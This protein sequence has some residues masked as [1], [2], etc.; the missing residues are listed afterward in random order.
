LGRGKVF[1]RGLGVLEEAEELEKEAGEEGEGINK[2]E[3][4]E[5]NPKKRVKVTVEE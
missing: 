5:M 2:I 1:G 4:R 3:V